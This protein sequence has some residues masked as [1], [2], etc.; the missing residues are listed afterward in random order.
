MRPRNGPKARFQ[1][2]YKDLPPAPLCVNYTRHVWFCSKI[3]LFYLPTCYAFST[4]KQSFLNSNSKKLIRNVCIDF[5]D[6]VYYKFFL[7]LYTDPVVVVHS[8]D[9]ILAPGL[10]IVLMIIAHLDF[11]GSVNCLHIQMPLSASLT[12]CYY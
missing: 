2:K 9:H 7:L 3:L 12:T 8:T 11:F 6:L 1:C 4:P 10:A 5:S